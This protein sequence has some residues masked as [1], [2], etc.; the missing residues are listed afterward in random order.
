MDDHLQGL[1]RELRNERCPRAVLDRVA[2]RIGHRTKLTR[3]WPRLLPWA[4]ASALVMVAVSAWY[5]P[6]RRDLQPTAAAEVQVDRALVIQQTQGALVYIGHAL[7]E[8]A[9]HTESTIL[10]QTVP[11]LQNA[12]R[13]LKTKVTNPL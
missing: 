7:I 3:R 10:N 13:T 4:I 12:F 5:W 1:V 9:A 6:S 2:E 8:A 11:P